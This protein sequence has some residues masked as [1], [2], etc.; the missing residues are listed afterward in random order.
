MIS[1]Q[2]KLCGSHI[3]RLDFAKDLGTIVES[4]L[5]FHHHVDYIFSK[6]LKLFGLIR[7][8]TLSFPSTYSLSMFHFAFASPI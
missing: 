3:N 7:V 6:A 1:S 4:K 2:Y 8:T 5:Y